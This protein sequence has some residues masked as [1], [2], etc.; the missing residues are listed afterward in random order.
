MYQDLSLTIIRLWHRM[1]LFPAP[2][3]SGRSVIIIC[4]HRFIGYSLLPALHVI[5]QIVV[6]FYGHHHMQ[7]NSRT[8]V[9]IAIRLSFRRW[10]KA[11]ALRRMTR[12]APRL[13]SI[14][15]DLTTSNL[16]LYHPVDPLSNANAAST[17]LPILWRQ[18]R[19][20]LATVCR[21]WGG[22]S[23]QLAHRPQPEQDLIELRE[24]DP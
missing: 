20:S 9:I 14:R 15:A 11:S 19:S 1:Q 10:S 18:D 8:T 21:C 17:N 12:N 6:F 3:S 24:M 23:Q 13:R 2:C 16:Q 5:G 4:S 7:V 22:R